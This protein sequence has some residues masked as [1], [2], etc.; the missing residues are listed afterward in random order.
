MIKFFLL[1]FLFCLLACSPVL[2]Q[3]WDYQWPMGYGNSPLPD[4]SVL[5]FNDGDVSTEVIFP[6]VGN[7]GIG[8]TGSFICDKQTGQVLLM[9]N[10]CRVYDNGLQ[11]VQGSDT[12]SPGPTYNSYC[13]GL[14]EDYPATQSNAILPELT[15]DSIYYVLHKDGDINS[16]LQDVVSYNFYLTTVVRKPG[17]SFYVKDKKLL[18]NTPMIVGKVT[19]C[20]NSDGTKWWTWVAGYDTNVFYKFLVGGTDTIQ[21]PFEQTIGDL[22]YNKQLGIAQ[23]AFSPDTKTLAINADTKL[24]KVYDFDNETGELSNF[25]NIAYPD[26]G[27]YARG[28]AFSPN[29]RF[30]YVSTVLNLYQIDLLDSSAVLVAHH[31]SYDEF[32][33]PVTIGYLHLGPD[34][35]LYADCGS[36]SHFVHVVDHPNEEG[37]ACQFQERAITTLSTIL[38]EFP[39]IP[40]YR[41]DGA[42]DSSIVLPVSTV[43]EEKTTEKLELFPNPATH[44]TQIELPTEVPSAMLSLFAS[45]GQPSLSQRLIAGWNT[46]QLE[47]LAPGLYFYEVRDK[48]RLLGSGK[49]V[50]VE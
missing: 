12:L 17:N 16:S 25:R 33:W 24:V 6:V 39:N 28:L 15:N 29:S 27:D 7:F 34:C 4:I 18:L 14:G 50:K 9:T 11:V 38:F 44:F 5:D 46:V 43:N 35:R 49:L 2:G 13:V 41:F 26:D 21:G 40:M 1:L 19:A 20:I 8:A 22:L 30:V 10:G 37:E 3:K 32:G 31:E 47:A 36:T 42:C 48:Q 23:A 45:T